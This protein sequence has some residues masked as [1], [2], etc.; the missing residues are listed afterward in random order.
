MENKFRLMLASSKK[1]FAYYKQL[2][3]KAMDQISDVD[4]LQSAHMYDNSI[5]VIVKHLHGNMMSR[6]TNIF[7]EDGEKTWRD[8]DGEFESDDIEKEAI[9]ALWESG[10]ARLFETLDTLTESDLLRI[11]YIRNEGMTVEDA[12]IRQLCH[13]SYHVGQIVHICK[14][15][16]GEDWQSLSIP[17]NQSKQYNFK[18]FAEVKAERHFIDSLMDQGK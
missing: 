7:T 18:K 8:R 17:K 6:W 9:L 15:L 1:Q 13:Y 2:G 12:I 14:F 3:D 16:K 11:I 5:Q 4:F 10:W